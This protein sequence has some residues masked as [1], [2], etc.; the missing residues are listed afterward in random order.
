MRMGT[1]D[2]E[3]DAIVGEMVGSTKSSR[4]ILFECSKD[5]GGI[6]TPSLLLRC[7]IN[8]KNECSRVKTRAL[9][10][11]TSHVQRHIGILDDFSWLLS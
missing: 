6:C 10:S 11:D 8:A 2:I 7:D 9:F 3:T 4:Q 5:G 1:A